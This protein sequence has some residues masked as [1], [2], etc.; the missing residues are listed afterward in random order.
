MNFSGSWISQ[1]KRMKLL[2]YNDIRAAKLDNFALAP[3]AM[4]LSLTMLAI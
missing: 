1:F 2:S 3:I 4:W